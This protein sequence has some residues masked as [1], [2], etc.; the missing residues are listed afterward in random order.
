MVT[1]LYSQLQV[2]MKI[3]R[4]KIKWAF[5]KLPWRIIKGLSFGTSLHILGLFYFS[6]KSLRALAFIYRKFED[7][8]PWSFLVVRTKTHSAYWVDSFQNSHSA[9]LTSCKDLNIL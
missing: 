6:L 7:E 3:K 4:E 1:L 2:N 8:N 9:Y 5:E